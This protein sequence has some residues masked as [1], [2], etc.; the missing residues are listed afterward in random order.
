MFQTTAVARKVPLVNVSTLAATDAPCSALSIMCL[1]LRGQRACPACSLASAGLFSCTVRHSAPVFGFGYSTRIHGHMAL[2]GRGNS[3]LSSFTV[4]VQ[5][6]TT[7]VSWE[8]SRVSC[9]HT[10]AC[11][12]DPA[13]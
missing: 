1:A 7:I 13:L 3:L 2:Q 5:S 6:A 11:A 10:S 8:L 12:E 9:R 4:G